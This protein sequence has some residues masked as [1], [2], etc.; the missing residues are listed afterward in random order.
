MEPTKNREPKRRYEKPTLVPSS[1]FGAEAA[2]GSCCRT[3][4]ATCSNAQRNSQQTTID[5]SKVRTST[6]S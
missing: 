3:S 6:A 4:N 5:A 2:V 1:V